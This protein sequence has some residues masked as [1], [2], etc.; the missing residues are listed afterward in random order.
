MSSPKQVV[1]WGG[2]G[3]LPLKPSVDALYNLRTGRLTIG[4][5]YRMFLS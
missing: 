5:F 4:H 2:H 1:I 3:V